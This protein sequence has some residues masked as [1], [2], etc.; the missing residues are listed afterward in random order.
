MGTARNPDLW[1]FCGGRPEAFVGLYGRPFRDIESG[2]RG[3][4]YPAD[5]R[6]PTGGRLPSRLRCGCILR[7]VEMLPTKMRAPELA[8]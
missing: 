3:L 1:D 2:S 8:G 6:I 4:T 7:A 5:L